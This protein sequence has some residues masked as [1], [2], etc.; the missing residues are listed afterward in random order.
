M[1]DLGIL[2]NEYRQASELSTSLSDALILLKKVY[3]KLSESNTVTAE[4]IDLTRN[5]L[6]NFL[7]ALISYLSP[8]KNSELTISKYITKSLIKRLRDK[9][10]GNL[11]YYLEDLQKLSNYLQESSL[12]LSENDFK[13]L[14]E[15]AAC[16]DAETSSVFQRM[17]QY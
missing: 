16:I 10:Q 6:S 9:H 12:V 3:Y 14:D 1:S 17:M 7:D 11:V 15:I 13:L 4:K 8:D 2:S 5:Q